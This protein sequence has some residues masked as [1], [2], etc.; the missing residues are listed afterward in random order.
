[1]EF[2][3][4]GKSNKYNTADFTITDHQGNIITQKKTIKILGYGVNEENTLENYISLLAG[5]ITGTYQKI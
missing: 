3:N 4:F 2:L 5:R 1:M